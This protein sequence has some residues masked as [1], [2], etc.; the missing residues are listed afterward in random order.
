MHKIEEIHRHVNLKLCAQLQKYIEEP[1]SSIIQNSTILIFINKPNG[2]TLYIPLSH[3]IHGDLTA[4]ALSRQQIPIFNYAAKLKLPQ[5]AFIADIYP[6]SLN[7]QTYISSEFITLLDSGIQQSF[8]PWCYHR[9]QL[10]GAIVSFYFFLRQRCFSEYILNMK[11]DLDCALDAIY[12]KVSTDNNYLETF[13][14]SNDISFCTAI[15][16]SLYQLDNRI[17]SHLRLNNSELKIFKL[18]YAGI[19]KNKEIAFHASL[20]V[21]TIE[22][23]IISLKRKLQCHS[24]EEMISK[25]N[26]LHSVIRSSTLSDLERTSSG[27]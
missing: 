5:N 24:K 14:I 4:H 20:S 2:Q 9:Y 26:T 13:D 7:Y 19:Y 15:H 17:M 6:Y 25:I 21:R 3:G 8:N 22:G 1:L 12:K 27:I 11:N 23:I 10:D 16:T 18:I